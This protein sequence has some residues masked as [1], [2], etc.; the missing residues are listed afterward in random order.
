MSVRAPS[1]S[2]V[3]EKPPPLEQITILQ[4]CLE[5]DTLRKENRLL[6]CSRDRLSSEVE[7]LHHDLKLTNE[8]LQ[9]CTSMFTESERNYSATNSTRMESCLICARAQELLS[10]EPARSRNPAKL[11]APPHQ[12][13]PSL[14]PGKLGACP[15]Q[16]L[17][18]VLQTTQDDDPDPSPRARLMASSPCS[19]ECS[20]AEL[21]GSMT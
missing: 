10:S 7:G 12:S 14:E 4:V 21:Y 1:A 5:L 18:S 19:K 13:S 15:K 16:G 2:A 8:A 6:R 9:E 17:K 11:E 20:E 3:E